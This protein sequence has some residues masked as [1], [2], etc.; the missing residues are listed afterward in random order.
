MSDYRQA[1]AGR[2]SIALLSCLLASGG[3]PTTDGFAPRQAVL[4]HGFSTS[5]TSPYRD[6]HSLD[7][8]QQSSASLRMVSYEQLA[9]QLPSK[10][11]IDAVEAK[12][13]G[14]VVASDVATVAGVSLSQARKDL[15]ALASLSR[16]D[17]AVDKEG[18]LI[19]SFPA[20]LPGVLSQNS[21][22]FKA[23]Q[24]F[25]KIWP[26]LFW[27]IR[28]SFGVTLLAS[29]VAIF[30]TIFF[31]NSSSSSD[32]DDRR[33][34][35]RGGGGGGMSFGGSYFWGPSPF[36]FFFYR[37]YGYYGYYGQPEATSDPEDMGILESVFS[38]IFGD[39][40]PNP[41]LEERRLSLAASVIRQNKGAVTA[42]QLAPFCDDAPDPSSVEQ[43]GYVDE[44]RI[45]E[46]PVPWNPV[47]ASY[48]LLAGIV[49]LEL[50]LTHCDGTGRRASCD[51]RWGDCLRLS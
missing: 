47:H 38:Y 41:N 15:T 13:G 33:R 39:G 3:L 34:D 10:T 48:P 30:S 14:K 16:G 18:E 31:I 45:V 21:A 9:E 51:R 27:F 28:V 49:Y 37:P 12:R 11:V 22:K 29:L 5:F 24:T 26:G 1:S 43:R 23:L 36:D 7:K 25:R 4:S 19:Y 40:N 35:D 32:N 17:I 6:M 2:L 8:F 42:E 20:N 46:I 50:R 44:V